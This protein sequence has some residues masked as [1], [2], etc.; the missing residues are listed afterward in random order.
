MKVIRCK[1]CVLD[2]APECPLSYV[3]NHSLRFVEHSPMF[4]CGK[5][6]TSEDYKPTSGDVVRNMTD[7]QLAVWLDG[8]ERDAYH[9]GIRGSKFILGKT[10][11]DFYTGFFG[12]PNDEDY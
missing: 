1:D 7:R 3:E 10:N 5:G 4:F 11:I 2:G 8:Q 12:H 6:K 9:A